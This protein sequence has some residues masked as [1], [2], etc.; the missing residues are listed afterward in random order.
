M[1]Q[2]KN[3][4]IKANDQLPFATTTRGFSLFILSLLLLKLLLFFFH[5]LPLF[6]VYYLLPRLY[7][8]GIVTATASRNTAGGDV[9]GRPRRSGLLVS[10]IRAHAAIKI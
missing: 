2:N 10:C 3:S 1:L 8:S 7:V 6:F 9:R 5:F 4:T